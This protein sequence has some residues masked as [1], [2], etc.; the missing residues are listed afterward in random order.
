MEPGASSVLAGFNQLWGLPP[1]GA[2]P[3]ALRKFR[4]RSLPIDGLT[5]P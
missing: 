2:G 3:L 4:R 5:E 1:R